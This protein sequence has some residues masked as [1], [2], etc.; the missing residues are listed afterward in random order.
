MTVGGG[1]I[2]L[3]GGAPQKPF[4][5]PS[6]E[7]FVPHIAFP[8]ILFLFLLF[9]LSMLENFY[10]HTM[11]FEPIHS[12]FLLITSPRLALK[13]YWPISTSI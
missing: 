5:M 2:L 13:K 8:F 10:V 7:L 6:L 11:Y 3:G 9:Y 4:E 1:E 12:H